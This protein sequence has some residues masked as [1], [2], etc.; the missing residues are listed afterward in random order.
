[1]GYAHHH[2]NYMREVADAIGRHRGGRNGCMLSL[3][4]ELLHIWHRQATLT[5]IS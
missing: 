5:D 2:P 1:L 3:L 4:E